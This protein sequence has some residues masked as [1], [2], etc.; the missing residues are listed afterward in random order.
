MRIGIYV[1]VL[2]VQAKT[3]I[4]RYVRGLIEA[5]MEQ[6][7]SNQYFL[8]YQESFDSK[9][10][11][12]LQKKQDNFHLRPVKFPDNWIGNHPSIWWKWYLPIVLKLDGINVF[13]G[14][15]HF[16][17]LKG[18]TKKVVTIHDIAYFYMPVHGTGMDRVL[19]QWTRLAFEAADTVVTVSEST[20]SDCQK[21][22]VPAEAIQNIYQGYEQKEVNA[23]AEEKA[24]KLLVERQLPDRYFLY[25]GTIQPRKNIEFLVE[26]FANVVDKIPHDLILAGPN[27]DSSEQVNNI[28]IQR[29]LESRVHLLGYVSDEERSS[30]YQC[31]SAFVYPSRYEGF[32]LVVLEAMSYDVPVITSNSSSLPEVSGDAALMVDPDNKEQLSNALYEI[33]TNPILA[34]T[35]VEK[36]RAQRQK[37]KWKQTAEQTIEL[38]SKLFNS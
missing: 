28:I 30:L 38:Y 21:E 25:L 24:R 15:N 35:L 20:K 17:P 5:L 23:V 7:K 18:K 36:G 4:S 34:E 26:S 3:G 27:G 19:E 8:Y 31:A 16:I 11:D 6:D 10:F 12:L 9:H 14:P 37:F 22:G 29:K 2:K 32:G 33:A 13:H 1:E